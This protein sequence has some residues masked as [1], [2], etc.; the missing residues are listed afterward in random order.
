M[1]LNSLGDT[2]VP[3]GYIELMRECWN[4]DPTRR[5]T[6]NSLYSGIGQIKGDEQKNP[7]KII[8]SSDIGPISSNPDAIYTSRPLSGMIKSAMNI[9]GLRSQ[10][11]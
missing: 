2:H 7:A 5:P 4:L 8:E 1:I 10:S 9:R 11:S 3:D 6:A